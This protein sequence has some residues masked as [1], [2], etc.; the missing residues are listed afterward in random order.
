MIQKNTEKYFIIMLIMSFN[1]IIYLKHISE[2]FNVIHFSARHL[3]A[4]AILHFI[5]N[6]FYVFTKFEVVKINFGK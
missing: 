5:I 3:N 1:F 4:I 6:F 2:M